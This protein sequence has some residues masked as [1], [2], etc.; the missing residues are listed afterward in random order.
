MCAVIYVSDIDVGTSIFV[1]S[2]DVTY[3]LVLSILMWTCILVMSVNMP[4]V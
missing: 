4:Y 3:I 1:M 2:V